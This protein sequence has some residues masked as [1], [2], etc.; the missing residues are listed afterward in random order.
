MG[1]DKD[2]AREHDRINNM[3]QSTLDNDNPDEYFSDIIEMDLD[4]PPAPCLGL[5][6]RKRKRPTFRCW[7]RSPR[8]VSN[9]KRTTTLGRRRWC[10]T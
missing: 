9:N 3:E 4:G 6:Q 7:Q 5:R 1:L 8:S 2:K 10:R